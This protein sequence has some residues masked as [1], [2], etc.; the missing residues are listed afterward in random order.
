[1]KNNPARRSGILLL[2]KPTGI[3][4]ARAVAVV[5]RALG[6][7]KV[8]HLGTLD[9][10]ASGLLP[11]CI[12]EATKITPFLN[13]A[14]KA[15][16]GVIQLGLRTDTLDGTGEVLEWGIGRRAM[17]LVRESELRVALPDFYRGA[18]RALAEAP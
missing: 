12:G 18:C 13:T 3:T 10:F 17:L 11:L 15:Y 4:S 16:R 5:R 2:D 1:M 8:G 7:P 9:P 14:D 6:K